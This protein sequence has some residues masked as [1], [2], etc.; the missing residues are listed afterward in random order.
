MQTTQSPGAVRVERSRVLAATPEQIFS[1]IADVD[2][3]AAI[4]PRVERVEVLSRAADHA[5]VRTHMA[6]GP[7]GSFSSEG[8][9]RW[10]EYRELTFSTRK[11]ASISTHWTLTPADAGTMLRVVM[12]LD[13]TPMLGP[14]AA[15]VPAESVA[16]IVAPDL[17]RMLEAI[18]GRLKAGAS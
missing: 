18:A 1:F 10:V 12:T 6:I 13:L 11:P 8:E 7:L 16:S 2:N 4:L 3:L 5:R 9:T 14:L 15:L 17:E